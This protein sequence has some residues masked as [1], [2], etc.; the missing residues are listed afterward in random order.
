MC[1]PGEEYAT[2]LSTT[3]DLLLGSFMLVILFFLLSPSKFSGACTSSSASLGLD[4]SAF[5]RM[6]FVPQAF[7]FFCTTGFLIN[8]C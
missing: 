3:W 2:N 7:F 1:L 4:I 5:Y 8:A 6:L